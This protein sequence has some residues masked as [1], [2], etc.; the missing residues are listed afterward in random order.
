MEAS[1]LPKISGICNCQNLTAKNTKSHLEIRLSGLRVL[2]GCVF[3]GLGFAV[4]FAV[5][6]ACCLRPMACSYAAFD[7]P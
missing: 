6:V 3:F 7:F 4:V 2:C 1:S 5:P